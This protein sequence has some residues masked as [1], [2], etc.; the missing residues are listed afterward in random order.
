MATMILQTIEK[1]DLF[2]LEIKVFSCG[3]NRIFVL[4]PLPKGGWKRGQRRLDANL[5]MA[6]KRTA[7]ARANRLP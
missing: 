7:M 4:R 5:P 1:K 3:A 2:L 6:R